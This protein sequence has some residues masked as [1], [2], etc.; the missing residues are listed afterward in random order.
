MARPFV[1]RCG[2]PQC[3]G[4]VAG[5]RHLSVD[6]LARYFVNPHIRGLAAAVARSWHV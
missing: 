3:V 4:F 1:R 5:A 2:A 6:V